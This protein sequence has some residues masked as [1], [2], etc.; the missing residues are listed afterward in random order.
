VV[1]DRVSILAQTFGK[2][3]AKGIYK[4]QWKTATCQGTL[5]ADMG[6]D[7]WKVLWDGDSEALN[8][9]TV[10]LTLLESAAAADDVVVAEEVIMPTT[11][12]PVESIEPPHVIPNEEDMPGITPKAAEIEAAKQM[13]VKQLR[14]ALRAKMLDHKGKKAALLSRYLES[15]GV[16][17]EPAVP[18]A[19]SPQPEEEIVVLTDSNVAPE[20]VPASMNGPALRAELD[21]RGLSTNGTVATLRNRLRVNIELRADAGGDGNALSEFNPPPSVTKY[22]SGHADVTWTLMP[23]GIKTDARESQ[24]QQATL[25]NVPAVTLEAMKEI[26]CWLIAQPRGK[27]G[28][29]AALTSMNKRLPPS[30]PAFDLGEHLLHFGYLYLAATTHGGH[31]TIFHDKMKPGIVTPPMAIGRR[32]GIGKRRHE[33]WKKHMLIAPVRVNDSDAWKF[34]RTWWESMPAARARDLATSFLLCMDESMSAWTGTGR[35]APADV[36]EIKYVKGCLPHESWV[37]RKPEPRGCEIK[38]LCDAGTYVMLAGEAEE[39]RGPM[40]LKKFRDKWPV[41]I[42]FNHS[43]FKSNHSN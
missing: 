5:R 25:A 16:A 17:A 34:Q 37:P 41:H 28:F 38:T 18:A 21:K 14:A 39:G 19:A 27:A 36:S 42:L 13:S 29:E 2:S 40:K 3:W 22:R 6:N 8:S 9:A 1:R 30:L 12:A 43:C 26:D 10:Q 31:E 4:A 20:I 15:L 11:P 7:Q 35:T 33:N 23:D 24:R 32:Y